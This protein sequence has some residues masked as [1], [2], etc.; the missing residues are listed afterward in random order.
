MKFSVLVSGPFVR[1]LIVLFF[2]SPNRN[3]IWFRIR[4]ILIRLRIGRVR[5][6][7]SDLNLFLKL[8]SDP[9]LNES[10]FRIKTCLFVT[11]NKTE[12]ILIIISCTGTGNVINK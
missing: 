12:R 2:F 6:I 7:N 3:K 5:V 4:K 10:V 11:E 8:E 1:I 9:N